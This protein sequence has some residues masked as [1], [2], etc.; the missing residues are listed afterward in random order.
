MHPKNL[1]LSLLQRERY[2]RHA[3]H[4]KLLEFLEHKTANHNSVHLTYHLHQP[5]RSTFVITFSPDRTKIATSHGNHTVIVSDCY[6]CKVIHTLHGHLR[7]PWCASFH[8]RINSIL[9]S[10]C[11]GGQVRLWDLNNI[12]DDNVIFSLQSVIA[13][14]SFH[15]VDDIL[16]IGTTNKIILF[17]WNQRRQLRIIQ[18]KHHSESV[19]LVRFLQYGSKLLTGIANASTQY[20]KPTSLNVSTRGNSSGQAVVQT[21]TC[22]R[23]QKRPSTNQNVDSATTTKR[24]RNKKSPN[25]Q[26]EGTTSA[27]SSRV[28]LQ[29]QLAPCDHSQEAGSSTNANINTLNEED[30]AS[31]TASA[32][33]VDS[34]TAVANMSVDQQSNTNDFQ[35][36]TDDRSFTQVEREE[37]SLNR[38]RLHRP[39]SSRSLTPLSSQ[40]NAV[41][42]LRPTSSSTLSLLSDETESNEDLNSSISFATTASDEDVESRSIN[43]SRQV[44]SEIWNFTLGEA[45]PSDQVMVSESLNEIDV[46]VEGAA[47]TIPVHG[48]VTFPSSDAGGHSASISNLS[49]MRAQTAVA[50]ATARSSHHVHTA[51]VIASQEDEHSEAALQT[52]VNRAIAGAFAGSGEGA[53]ANNIID[54]THR[55]Q[56]WDSNCS[57][58]PDIKDENKNVV[59]PFCKIHND[60]SVDVSQ[61]GSLVAVFVPSE[62]GF[63][64][65]AQLQVISLRPESYLQ[66]IYSRKYGPNAVS[67]SLSPLSRFVLVGLASRKLHWHLTAH[68]LVGQILQLPKDDE[69]V[70][71]DTTKA[72]SNIL[73]KCSQTQRSNVSVNT[74]RFHPS[75]GMGIIYG[76]NRGHIQHC[77]IGPDMNLNEKKKIIK[78]KLK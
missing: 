9:A 22:M 6:S 65:D 19:R 48:F 52:A 26:T 38:L 49:R 45:M 33:N 42:T 4:G 24:S 15:P 31:N 13:S 20:C 11:L 53:V 34:A 8:P 57:Q 76:T 60:S 16:A 32:L 74:V 23:M 67:V 27:S 3:S 12:T 71:S 66:C 25:V 50:T 10:G 73:H 17:D 7:T 2:G 75:P 69:F 37:V 21:V 54:T 35:H 59:V 29:D 40:M 62:H 68:Q 47:S 78:K 18:T 64:M 36:N 44:R 51:V 41:A 43:V 56:L 61:D 63:P 55:L 77:H 58:Y 39:L 5:A 70:H 28:H 72:L 14:I 30:R 1:T 46:S